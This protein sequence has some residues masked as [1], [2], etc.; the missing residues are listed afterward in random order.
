MASP[1]RRLL[2]VGAGWT[3]LTVARLAAEGGVFVDVLERRNHLGGNAYSSP[4]DHGLGLEVHRYGMHIFHTRSEKVWRFVKRFA[5]WSPYQH[6]VTTTAASGRR[7]RLPF[8]H[9]T[10]S[11]LGLERRWPTTMP[12]LSN[13]ETFG[14]S[15][16]GDT[17]YEELVHHYTEKQWGRAPALLPAAVLGRLPRRE[18]DDLGYF[19]DTYCALPDRGYGALFQALATDP[20]VKVHL[21]VTTTR[22]LLDVRHHVERGWPVVW[23]GT[24]DDLL[25]TDRPNR[26]PWRGLSWWH[27]E[28]RSSPWPYP[29]LNDGRPALVAAQTRTYNWGMLPQAGR[30]LDP[31]RPTVLTRE[32][33]VEARTLGAECYPLPLPRPRE[34]QRVRE[35]EVEARYR[36]LVHLAGRLGTYRYLNMDQAIAQAMTLWEKKL[37][38]QF[39]LP[40]TAA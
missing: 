7:V 12:D 14:R 34:L 13:L 38:P 33:P 5:A 28:V 37:S 22:T 8:S 24:V 25:L 19:D 26:L 2:V 4:D 10:L 6:H 23:T 11:D 27:E 30:A 18:N 16:L 3:G 1:S 36:G 15:R 17:V 9:A 21:N 31:R 40:E 29:V 35:R 39:N 32:I 20:L